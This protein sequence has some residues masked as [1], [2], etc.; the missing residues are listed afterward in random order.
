MNC[1]KHR[2]KLNRA[3]D[4]HHINYDKLLSV[5]ENCCALCKRCNV[6]VNFNRK[7]WIPFF[8]SLLAERYGY[9]YDKDFNIIQN[10]IFK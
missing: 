1:G 2:E 5:P 9:E 6:E 10:F 8:Q 4:V 3:L 7:Q